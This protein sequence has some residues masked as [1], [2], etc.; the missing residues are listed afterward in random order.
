MKKKL[1]G[2]DAPVS[3]FI[4]SHQIMFLLMSLVMLHHVA[5]SKYSAG[6][7]SLFSGTD[8]VT[9]HLTS[10][11]GR[12]RPSVV[13]LQSLFVYETRRKRSP[14]FKMTWFFDL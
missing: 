10:R 7:A 6:E 13:D 8:R 12:K 5:E 3:S 1:W 14:T 2:T 11:K 4:L 9:D